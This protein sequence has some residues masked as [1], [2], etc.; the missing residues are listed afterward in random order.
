MAFKSD[1]QRKAFFAHKKE[2]LSDISKHSTKLKE[3]QE[4]FMT[5]A[6]LRR[7]EE[8][9]IK[10]KK[11]ERIVKVSKFKASKFGRIVTRAE[12]AGKESYRKAVAYEKAHGKEQVDNLKRRGGKLLKLIGKGVKKLSK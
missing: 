8:R 2:L 7:I 4:E 3:A 9:L 12:T 10:V 11:A 5:D 6:E 1:K